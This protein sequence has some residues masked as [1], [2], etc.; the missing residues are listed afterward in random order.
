[1][2]VRQPSHHV[3][4]NKIY[5]IK[6]SKTK[7]DSLDQKESPCS[8]D[9]NYGPERCKTLQTGWKLIAK[10]NCTLPWMSTFDFPGIKPCEVG[11]IPNEG[12]EFEDLDFVPIYEI[13]TNWEKIYKSIKECKEL[14]P[15]NRT[16]YQDLIEQQSSKVG[17]ERGGSTGHTMSSLTIQYASPYI[18]V[19]KDS[20]SYDMQSLIGEVGGTLGLLLSLSF[21]SIFDLFDHILKSC[22]E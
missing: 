14:L 10:Y 15:C 16:V 6:L 2:F 5:N 17:Y 12:Q 13:V 22:F 21:I 19:I 18:Q 9:I 3:T 4:K 7:F 1:M 8:E 11:T 20:Y